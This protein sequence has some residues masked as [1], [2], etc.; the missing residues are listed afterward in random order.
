MHLYWCRLGETKQRNL[1]RGR[2]LDTVALALRLRFPSLGRLSTNSPG[3]ENCS[4]FLRL[5]HP[6][7]SI[8][9][10]LSSVVIRDIDMAIIE[11]KER[12]SNLAINNN[13]PQPPRNKGQTRE[14]KYD[15]ALC[16]SSFSLRALSNLNADR[17]CMIPPS[18]QGPKRN[19]TLFGAASKHSRHYSSSA[20]LSSPL[21]NITTL[22]PQSLI[23]SVNEI[24][25]LMIPLRSLLYSTLFRPIRNLWNSLQFDSWSWLQSSISVSYHS[26]PL[27][28]Q[29]LN[30]S[31]SIPRSFLGLKPQKQHPPGPANFIILI[32]QVST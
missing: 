21:R 7:P 31:F 2:R 19:E 1:A 29:V 11:R 13:R 17:K 12:N 4:L 32:H 8:H 3:N 16:R 25:T 10:H 26:L 18:L 27:F 9:P 23:P 5:L 14:K 28:D 20:L 22:S 15:L 6:S 30:H 24:S